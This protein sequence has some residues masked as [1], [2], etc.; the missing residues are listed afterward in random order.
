MYLGRDPISGNRKFNWRNKVLSV[1][2]EERNPVD[3]PAYDF[4]CV[5]YTTTIEFFIFLPL[6][7][8]WNKRLDH[9]TVDQY[10]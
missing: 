6:E 2:V 1:V 8:L 4:I 9:S 3:N 10:W 7:Y 5:K